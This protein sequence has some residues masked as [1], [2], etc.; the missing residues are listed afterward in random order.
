MATLD[1]NILD[2]AHKDGLLPKRLSAT[3]QLYLY[4]SVLTA[5]QIYWHIV[6]EEGLDVEQLKHRTG[7][8]E[9]TVKQFC[10]WLASKELIYSETYGS[11]RRFMFF[12]T[13]QRKLARVGR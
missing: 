11:T 7:L 8:H 4:P 10:R 6:G 1:L 3:Q 13:R 2:A 5:N 12:A 9:N